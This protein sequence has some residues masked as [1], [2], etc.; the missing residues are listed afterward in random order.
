MI[1]TTHITKSPHPTNHHKKNLMPLRVQT[2]PASQSANSYLSS[3]PASQP[4]GSQP[5]S[6]LANSQPAIQVMTKLCLASY[7]GSH[8]RL[9]HHR[10]IRYHRRL[11]VHRRLRHHRV[12]PWISKYRCRPRQ[13]PWISKQLMHLHSLSYIYNG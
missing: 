5:A 7:L 10:H 9:H 6:Q 11:R 4:T 2:A 13:R 12:C 3:Q 8:H 1:F